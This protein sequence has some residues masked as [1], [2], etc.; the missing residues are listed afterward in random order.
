MPLI[1]LICGL[2][3]SGKTTLA[4]KLT[5]NLPSVLWLNA[6]SIR[7]SY[8]DWDFSLSGRIRQAN[9]LR[10]MANVSEYDYVICDFVAPTT[11]IR[12]IFNA[13]YTIWMNT[14]KEGRFDDTN[15]LFENPKTYNYKISHHDNSHID[16]ILSDV[17]NM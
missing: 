16:K 3:G 4:E 17:N 11:E 8:N 13:D 9:R 15:K 2:P 1:I 12:K 7:K 14:I 5:T 10:A 6:D